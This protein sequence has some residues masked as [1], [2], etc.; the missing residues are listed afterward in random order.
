VI[1]SPDEDITKPYALALRYF[2]PRGR[3]NLGDN[4]EIGGRQTNIFIGEYGQGQASWIL[5]DGSEA[6]IR[7]RGLT[8][9][10]LIAYAA[11]LQPRDT[12]SQIPGFDIIGDLPNNATLIGESIGSVE[13]A[14]STSYC[15]LE[16]GFY[17]R[18]GLL[19]GDVVYRFGAA[20]DF[21]PLPLVQQIG[22]DQVLITI[23]TGLV[24]ETVLDDV[25]DATPEQ[26]DALLIDVDNSGL[27]VALGANLSEGTLWGLGIGR[28]TPAEAHAAQFFG[29]GPVFD[30]GWFVAEGSE[31]REYDCLVGMEQ[32][33]LWWGDASFAFSR[34]ADGTVELWSWTVGDVRASDY[35]DRYQPDFE[36]PLSGTGIETEFGIAVGSNVDEFLVSHGGT[37]EMTEIEPDGSRVGLWSPDLQ[38]GTA[39]QI[40]LLVSPD[41]TI[42]GFGATSKPC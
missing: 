11:A 23:G 24:P 3:P 19:Q 30:T 13:G 12:D 41:G 18:I 35:G 8:R 2:D 39:W 27:G 14:G 10:E 4:V 42:E 28:H 22:S 34:T 26:W 40:A 36:Q 31:Q 7:S 29:P 9:E 5:P 38:P 15:L 20:I 6:Y 17:L 37:L 16:E 32:R 1:G 33:I 21:I 25:T